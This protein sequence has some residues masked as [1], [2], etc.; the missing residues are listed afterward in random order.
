MLQ[1]VFIITKPTTDQT[2]SSTL[3]V[4]LL[5]KAVQLPGNVV[6]EPNVAV[7]SP[8]SS[9]YGATAPVKFDFSRAQKLI[10]LELNRRCSKL[11]KNMRYDPKTSIDL[12]RDVAQQLRRVIK[13]ETL[14]CARYKIIVI[15]SVVQTKPNRQI[16]QSVNIVSRCLWDQDTDGS[17]TVQS[18]LGHDMFVT[19]TLFA[20]YTD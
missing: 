10:Q 19:A 14:N 3:A 7:Q 6:V 15:G 13:P 20:V 4:P 11:S 5:N 17:V 2:I 18:K 16:H 12:A 1:K 9:A 8:R